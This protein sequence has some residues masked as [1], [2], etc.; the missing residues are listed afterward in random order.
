MPAFTSKPPGSGHR[1]HSYLLYFPGKLGFTTQLCPVPWQEGTGRSPDS[2]RSP[3]PQRQ[4]SSTSVHSEMPLP[5]LGL[6]L[7]S[8]WPPGSQLASDGGICPSQGH[9][10]E[11]L[12]HGQARCPQ[13]H[14]QCSDLTVFCV[15][16]V[17]PGHS[18][19]GHHRPLTHPNAD[20]SGQPQG[21]AVLFLSHPSPK[22]LSSLSSAT[23]HP[24]LCMCLTASALL[25]LHF[26]IAYVFK[27]G[28]HF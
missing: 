24:H 7:G 23:L 27:R 20:G 18:A 28:Q 6:E 9:M 16:W 13:K 21:M 17:H 19:A 1:S 11:W 15:L 2:G 22:Q 12:L 10:A 26:K 14:C 5:P 25:I 4:V 3:G 8:L